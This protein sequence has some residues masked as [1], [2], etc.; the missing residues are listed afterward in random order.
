M[1]GKAMDDEME[2][3]DQVVEEI[4][5]NWSSG[6]PVQKRTKVMEIKGGKKIYG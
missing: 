3:T 2:V 4:M 5:V 6:K 1:K